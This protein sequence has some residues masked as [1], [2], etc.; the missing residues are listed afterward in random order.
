M[1]KLSPVAKQALTLVLA[2][3]SAEADL[4]AAQPT[5]GEMI[6]KINQHFAKHR[7]PKKRL[8][9]PP[10]WPPAGP[11]IATGGNSAWRR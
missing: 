5:L 8:R 11:T 6:A 4:P 10:P 1:R 2:S 3:P 7:P 9:R